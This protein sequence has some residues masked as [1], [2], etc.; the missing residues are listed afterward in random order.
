MT[1]P[2]GQRH[3]Q[4][5][6]QDSQRYTA[7]DIKSG[8]QGIAHFQHLKRL[9][10]ERA[11]GGETATET[12][13]QKQFHLR[14]HGA[15]RHQSREEPDQQRAHDVDGE[16][17]PRKRAFETFGNEIAPHG[18][19]GSAKGHKKNVA[20]HGANIAKKNILTPDNTKKNSFF[21]G[22]VPA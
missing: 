4:E 8:K 7:A 20:N 2:V 3:T 19:D 9:V 16:R 14:R 15:L 11:K 18:T 13:H 12:R 17:S 21:F 10:G 22:F 1:S 6:G 5:H